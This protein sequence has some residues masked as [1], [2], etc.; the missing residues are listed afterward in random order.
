MQSLSKEIA[1]TVAIP[2]R[3]CFYFAT[4]ALA[5]YFGGYTL[6]HGVGAY[7]FNN[8]DTIT[9][10]CATFTIG[11]GKGSESNLDIVTKFARFYCTFASQ[12]SVYYRDSDGFTWLIFAS[13][14]R[15]SL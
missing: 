1:I 3:A 12:E 5:N 9:E 2:D 13:G 4:K 8:G 11:T 10:D 14:V 6:T 15:C 7:T